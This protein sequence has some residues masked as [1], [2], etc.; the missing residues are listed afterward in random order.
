MY[1]AIKHTEHPFARGQLTSDGVQYST[2]TTVSTTSF[3][4]VETVSVLPPA[5]LGDV[6]EYEFGLT[7]SVQA[8]IT[9]ENLNLK[10][11]AKN[12]GDDTWVDISD[13]VTYAASATALKEYTYSGNRGVG[14]NLNQA[15]IEVRLVIASQA[16]TNSGT[17][18]GKTKNSSYVSIVYK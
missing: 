18:K 7:C 6:L 13:P 16:T 3:G 17:A 15:N 8:S 9:G 11:Q 5:S 14:T 12:H 4:A 10:W 2:L 1:Q